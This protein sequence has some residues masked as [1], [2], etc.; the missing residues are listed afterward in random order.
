MCRQFIFFCLIPFVAVDM[1]SLMC[2]GVISDRKICQNKNKYRLEVIQGHTFEAA[3]PTSRGLSAAVERL[4]ST[5][6]NHC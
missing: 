3:G 6:D 5:G 1:A 2:Y 4:V